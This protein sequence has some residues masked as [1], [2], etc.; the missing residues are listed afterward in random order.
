[1]NRL[2][3]FLAQHT[4]STFVLMG[5]ACGVFGLASFNLAYL[6]K[7]NLTLF[8]DYGTMVIGEGAGQ[9]L[10]ELIGYGY[11]ALSGYLLFKICEHSLVEHFLH[12]VTPPDYRD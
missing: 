6:F 5:I 3:T 10:L 7:A 12:R 4:A 8:L 2:K 11:L 9:Q 1:M